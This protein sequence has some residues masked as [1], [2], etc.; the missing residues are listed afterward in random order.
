MGRVVDKWDSVVCWQEIMC[1]VKGRGG[2]LRLEMVYVKNDWDIFV[3]EDDKVFRVVVGGLVG[4]KLMEGD[5]DRLKGERVV[6]DENQGFVVE[7][8]EQGVVVR[9]ELVF[10]GGE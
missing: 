5:I 2:R 8:M 6:G 7:W 4:D 9:Q 3:D 10:F 1:E